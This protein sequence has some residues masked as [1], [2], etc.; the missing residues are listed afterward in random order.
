MIIL[1]HK[2]VNV[3]WHILRHRER[4]DLRKFGLEVV[5]GESEEIN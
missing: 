1:I 2:L 5:L 3:I 4:F